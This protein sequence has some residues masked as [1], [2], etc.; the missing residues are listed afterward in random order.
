MTPDP[1]QTGFPP[2]VIPPPPPP[3][4]RREQRGSIIF[5]AG[6]VFAFLPIIITL[7]ASIFVDDAFNEGMS[8]WGTLP[9]LT[10]LTLPI[11]GVIALIGLV[12][13]AGNITS[14]RR[15]PDR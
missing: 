11:G 14:R 4:R 5:V 2:P 8:A 1:D 9:W 15:S 12:I 6:V 7:V 13:G 3:A 10:I